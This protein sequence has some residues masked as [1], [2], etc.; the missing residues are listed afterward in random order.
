MTKF[1]LE[2]PPFPPIHINDTDKYALTEL[3]DNL[4]DDMIEDYEKNFYTKRS[5]VDP[6]QWVRVKQFEDVVVYQ[7]CLDLKERRLSRV[8][9]LRDR[10]AKRTE[11]LK[12]LWAGTVLGSLDDIMYAV[13]NC[14]AEEAKVKAA[15][16]ESNTLDFALLDSIKFPTVDDP[17]R[18]VQVKWAVNGGPAIMRSVVRCRDFVYVESTGMTATSTGERIGFHLLHSITLPGAPDLQNHKLVRGDLSLFHLYRQKSD[19]VVE[20]HVRGFFDLKGDMP[21]GVATKLSTSGV[22]SA[23]KLG[24]YALMK[25]LHWKLAQRLPIIVPCY[26][27]VCRVCGRGNMPRRRM[28]SI[29][30]NQSCARCCVPKKM[31]F[32]AARSRTVVQKAL[33]VCKRCIQTASKA[34]GLDVALDELSTTG[35]PHK[36]YTYPK[37]AAASPTTSSSSIVL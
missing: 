31:F 30:M 28:C 10:D 8:N 3:A 22:V 7:D 12:L 27:S 17:F 29:C 1:P 11:V 19:G 18:S 37:S 13:V 2:H 25:K 23:W 9:L 5:Q 4:T 32:M 36:S 24:E 21:L 15:Y 20:I 14:T 26:P 34:N 33:S 35:R 16:V 6:R